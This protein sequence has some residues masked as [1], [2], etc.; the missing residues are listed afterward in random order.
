MATAWR[1]KVFDKSRRLFFVPVRNPVAV[2]A[3]G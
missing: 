3:L 2:L 1:T